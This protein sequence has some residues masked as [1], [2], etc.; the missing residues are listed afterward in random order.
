MIKLPNTENH[1]QE[2]DLGNVAPNP[3]G[4]YS[5][6]TSYEY[7][8]TVSYQG[9][10]YMCIAELGAT[11]ISPLPGENTDTWQMLTLPGDLTPEYI[12]AHDDVVAKAKQVA[13]SRAAVELSQ[14]EVEAAQVDVQQT[15]E[16]TRTAAREAEASRD[17]AS[18]SAQAAEASRTAAKESEDN[19]H[20]L[21][22]GFDERVAEDTEKAKIAVAEARQQ[23]V[24]VVES[25]KDISIQA[26]KDQTASYIAEKETSA[27]TKIGNYTSEK[28]AEI[29]KKASEANTTL[30][31][32]IADGTALK[33]QLE[34]TISTAAKTKT[35]LDASNT[36]AGKTKTALDASNT[37]A[38]KTKAD[39]DASNATALETKTGL[40]ATNKTAAGLTTSLGDKITE[41]TQVKT[42]I[43]TTGETAMSNLQAEAAKQQE[44]IKTSIDDTL[45]ISGK[46]ADAAVVG[47]KLTSATEIATEKLSKVKGKNLFDKNSADIVDG[48]FI[49]STGKPYA[50][51]YSSVYYATGYIPIKPNTTYALTDYSLSGAGIAILDKRFNVLLYLQGNKELKEAAGIFTTPEKA[52]FVRLSGNISAKGRNQLEEGNAI[53]SYEKYTDFLPLTN[54]EKEVKTV[55]EN[56]DG[57]SVNGYTSKGITGSATNLTNGESITLESPNIKYDKHL[58]FFSH[59]TSFSSLEIGRTATVW[60]ASYAVIDATNIT[61]YK[62]TN[63]DTQVAQVAHGLTFADYIGVTIDVE[64]GVATINIKT[65]GG[66][67]SA[68]NIA[69]DGAGGNI[70]VKS[71]GSELSNCTLSWFA[72]C[73]K[74]DIWAFGDSYFDFYPVQMFQEGHDKFMV[75][76][77]SGRGASAALTSFKVNLAHGMP[78]YAL[79]CMGMNN[80]DSEIA[81]NN[82]WLTATE[83][84]IS[85]CEQHYIIPILCTIPNVRGGQVEDTGI[86]NTRINTFKNVW[87]RNSGNRYIDLS[88]AVGAD[89]NYD[90]YD[91]MLDTN[92]VHPTKYGTQA[93]MAKIYADFPEILE[94]K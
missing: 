94:S 23:A 55:K 69:W 3:R 77:Y 10:S 14:Q 57:L 67:Y 9:G 35:T 26:V 15:H 28:I 66:A 91:G 43:Q 65:N 1:Y 25:Q 72:D 68:S 7:L 71:V 64:V 5:A 22:T 75:D 4:A 59:I 11:G 27:K 50:N 88:L 24:N 74:Y 51:R 52:A 83:E 48:Y 87:V 30:A 84:F 21:T 82:T 31:N 33:T 80:V 58:S 44:Y 32:T 49:N 93:I 46:A 73:W 79:W 13:A 38:A 89:D 63:T 61:V 90:W 17:S 40:D 34:T 70:Y 36:A 37:T 8:D 41:G 86:Y 12:A 53:T 60:G 85:I 19:V 2:T 76:M 62:H 81:I 54:L 18:G 78:K 20:A 92:G 29:N 47:E 42:D 16:D 45:S 56:L 39:L 6:T